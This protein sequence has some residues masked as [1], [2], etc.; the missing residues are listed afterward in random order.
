MYDGAQR[1]VPGGKIGILG[2]GTCGSGFYPRDR[3]LDTVQCGCDPFPHV[4]KC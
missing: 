1:F 4:T 3:G 2:Q